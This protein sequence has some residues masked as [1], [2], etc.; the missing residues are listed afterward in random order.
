L[1]ATLLVL[2]GGCGAEGPVLVPVEGTVTLD[3]QPVKGASVTFMPQFAG[4]PAMGRTDAAGAFTLRTHPHGPGA[5][6]GTHHVSVR[7]M[8]VT[9]IEADADGLSG[10]I[11]PE[12]VQETWHTPQKYADAEESGLIVEVRAGMDPVK[13]ELQTP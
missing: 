5:M 13:L 12:G 6:P 2:C 8:E 3:G 11:A 9:G 7:K 1:T 4:Q 10:E